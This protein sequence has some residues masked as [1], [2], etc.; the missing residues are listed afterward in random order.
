MEGQSLQSGSTLPCVVVLPVHISGC[1]AAKYVV[2]SVGYKM[3]DENISS[4]ILKTVHLWKMAVRLSRRRS[5]AENVD[6]ENTNNQQNRFA[7]VS[8]VRMYVR[9]LAA[10]LPDP[11]LSRIPRH[12]VHLESAMPL[13]DVDRLQMSSVHLLTWPLMSHACERFHGADDTPAVTHSK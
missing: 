1:Q 12:K 3:N 8:Y 9:M 10:L 13:R 7:L 6:D 11:L 5:R 2:T 4:E